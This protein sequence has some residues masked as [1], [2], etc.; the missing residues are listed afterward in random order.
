MRA[1]SA[2]PHGRV[3]RHNGGAV[4]RLF[5]IPL[6]FLAFQPFHSQAAPV[7]KSLQAQI[8]RTGAWHQGCPVGFSGLRVLTVTFWG[9]DGHAHTGQLVTNRS[10]AAPLAT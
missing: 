3:K 5:A 4:A 2:A 9:F 10:A 8:K 6:V 1:F 7:P